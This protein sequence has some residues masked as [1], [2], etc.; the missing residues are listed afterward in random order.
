MAT[1]RDQSGGS[2]QD[3]RQVE[4]ASV[5]CWGILE[6]GAVAIIFRSYLANKSGDGRLLQ[7]Q[8]S[9]NIFTFVA[10]TQDGEVLGHSSTSLTIYNITNQDS[11]CVSGRCKVESAG[12]RG[13]LRCR[14]GRA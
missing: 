12:K 3:E 13:D 7:H 6:L 9:R 5:R 2:W 14:L 8:L 11:S 4:H 10:V 1:R